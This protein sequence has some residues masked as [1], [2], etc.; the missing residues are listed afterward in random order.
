M[1]SRSILSFFEKPVNAVN[2]GADD[3][4]NIPESSCTI[5]NG[6][7]NSANCCSLPKM[8]YHRWKDFVF[9]K[10]KFG[11][12][13]PRSCQHIWFDNYPRL[14]YDIEKDYVVCFFCMK[15]LSKQK[16][17]KNKELAYISVG[18]KN[19]KKVPECFKDHQN[20]KC[21]KEAAILAV[22]TYRQTRKLDLC[23]I[24]NDLISKNHK[25]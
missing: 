25:R 16:A 9:L 13:N 5:A 2:N 17:E 1:S 12:Q 21:Y 20:S 15:N 19:W 22:I 4:V 11:S 3:V 8:S 24:G 23:K 6:D 14:H 18:F 7:V 10:T